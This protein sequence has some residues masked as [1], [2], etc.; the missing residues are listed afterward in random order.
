MKG[1]KM[2]PFRN[3]PKITT[4]WIH[5][6][7]KKVKEN[8]EKNAYYEIKVDED[9]IKLLFRE[10]KKNFDKKGRKEQPWFSYLEFEIDSQFAKDLKM[11]L[12]EYIKENKRCSSL[13]R[14]DS[15]IP[16]VKSE[17]S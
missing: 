16:K 11:F 9:K 7:T 4:N 13:A 17:A 1:T 14:K 8:E 2:I 5:K 6:K 12:D 15:T 3:N 10:E